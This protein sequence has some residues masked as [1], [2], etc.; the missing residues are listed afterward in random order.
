MSAV[1]AET[2][3]ITGTPNSMNQISGKERVGEKISYPQINDKKK[4]DSASITYPYLCYQEQEAQLF[5]ATLN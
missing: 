2:D 3:K 4:F 5:E 1:S